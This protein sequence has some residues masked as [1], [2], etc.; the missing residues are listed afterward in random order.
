MPHDK[1][2]LVDDDPDLVHVLTLVLERHGYAVVAAH[3]A[4]R[5]A[6]VVDAERPDLIVL[7][8]M[9]PEGTEGFHFV[10]NLRNQPDA[11]SRSVP[12]VMLTAIHQKTPL[13][14]YPDSG[15]GTYEAGEYLPV[16]GFVDKPVEP[17]ALVSEVERV[18]AVGQKP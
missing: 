8:V 12:I 4:K 3:D 2:L 5:G 13:R 11:Y 7:D 6:E 15:D 10:W 16:Q 14:F 17:S 1:I 18:L 9:M